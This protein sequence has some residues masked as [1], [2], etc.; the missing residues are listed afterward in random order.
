MGVSTVRLLL[1]LI[2]ITVIAISLYNSD[3]FDPE[4]EPEPDPE[5]EPEPEPE[6]D[7]NDTLVYCDVPDKDD[8][9]ESE[10]K[11]L[12]YSVCEKNDY[13]VYS[14]K[15]KC[16]NKIYDPGYYDELTELSS[17]DKIYCLTEDL[18]CKKLDF[19]TCSKKHI[20]VYLDEDTCESGKDGYTE[21]S[22]CGSSNGNEECVE[23]TA[24]DECPLNYASEALCLS[25]NSIS[26]SG[27]YCYVDDK[28]EKTDYGDCAGKFYVDETTCEF[29]NNA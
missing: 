6:S 11:Q 10:C 17:D 24:A 25:G 14:T 20:Q 5:P 19:E 3:A 16:E 23:V 13:T 8:S 28:C 7:A 12:K 1:T 2:L 9:S 29:W 22:W 21:K 15:S 27:G 26:S 4:P 18:E